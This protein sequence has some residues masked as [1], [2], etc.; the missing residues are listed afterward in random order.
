M[1][2]PVN[3][4]NCGSQLP[5]G[6][7]SCA[8]CGERFDVEPEAPVAAAPASQAPPPPKPPSATPS[9]RAAASASG[10]S[11]G[12]VAKSV[13]QYLAEVRERWGLEATPFF[14]GVMVLAAAAILI[15]TIF[16]ILYLTAGSTD[17]NKHLDGGV[18]LTSATALAFGALVVAILVRYDSPRSPPPPDMQSTDFR[19]GLAISGVTVLFA[20][21]GAILGM[22]GRAEAAGSWEKYAAMFAFVSATWFVL[23]QPV[24]EMIGATKATTIGLIVAAVALVMLL[25]GQIQG[26]SNSYDTY[27]GGIS[28]QAMAISVVVLDLGW[29]LGMQP[30]RR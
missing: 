21:L 8:R 18:W 5:P 22:S 9:P 30:R 25:I 14:I 26:L 7:P 2:T 20:L 11:G 15:G 12:D 24:P 3:C 27:I 6:A 16:H 10:A 1:A 23:S 4:P 28:W 29:F 17:V 13:Q 19:T